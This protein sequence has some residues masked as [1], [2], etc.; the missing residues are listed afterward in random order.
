ML[1]RIR[2]QLPYCML[3]WNETV[4]Y[5]AKLLTPFKGKKKSTNKKKR[6]SFLSLSRHL[7]LPHTESPSST[8]Q[9]NGISFLQYQQLYIIAIPM[10]LTGLFIYSKSA[11]SM[12]FM[13]KI[14]KEA[15]ASG[16]LTICIANISSYSVISGLAMGMERISSQAC[17]A[18]QWPLMG[19]TLRCTTITL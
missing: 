7:L 3:Y 5:K 13:G 9:H 8:R 11:I 18:K 10:I 6:K 16:S 14:G 1:Y 17:R 4:T 15:L 12:F 19:K 2:I